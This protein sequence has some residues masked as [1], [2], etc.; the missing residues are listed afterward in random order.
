MSQG[1]VRVE[2]KKKNDAIVTSKNYK[3]RADESTEYDPIET[4]LIQKFKQIV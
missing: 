3:I 1:S 2:E 4:Q